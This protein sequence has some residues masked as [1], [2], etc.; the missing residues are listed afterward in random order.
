MQCIQDIQG[1]EWL[2]PYEKLDF[3][4][5][6]GSGAF[7]VVKKVVAH[8]IDPRDWSSKIAAV[9]MLKGQRKLGV[10]CG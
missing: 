6:L 7:G 10:G 3:G 9:K 4:E 8:S 5:E 2:F 1:S